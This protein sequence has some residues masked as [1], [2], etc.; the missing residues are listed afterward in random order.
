MLEFY[1]PSPLAFYI[2]SKQ[3]SNKNGVT[4]SNPTHPKDHLINGCYLSSHK[5]LTRENYHLWV[6]AYNVT[7]FSPPMDEYITIQN[8][9]NKEL[10]FNSEEKATASFSETI[11]IPKDYMAQKLTFRAAVSRWYGSDTGWLI[12]IGSDNAWNNIFINDWGLN[13]QQLI[14][15]DVRESIAISGVG[16]S[17]TSCYSRIDCKLTNYGFEQWQI[18][19]YSN[20]MESYENMKSDYENAIS[21]AKIQSG[22]TITANNPELNRKIEREELQKW[23]T[24]A[25]LLDR[26]TDWN[27]MKKSITGEPEIDWNQV[28]REAPIVSFMNTAFEWENMTYKFLP[29]YYNNKADH[30]TIREISEVDPKFMDALRA[31]YARVIVPA[32]NGFEIA[33]MHFIET[34]QVWN[35]GDIPVLNDPLFQSI[36]EDIYSAEV[37]SNG[38]P[39]GAPWETKLPTTLIWLQNDQP[40]GQ[41]P[42]IL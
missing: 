41:L 33:I 4:V 10:K 36:A 2:F 39:E 7:D 12:L 21:A 35:G 6:T 17:A 23:C 3:G 24:E 9:F 14:L 42:I 15:P 1:I 29:Y 26:F 31:G 30:P 8:A 16:R 11:S 13:P 25:M 34:G 18:E 20:I 37:E 40:D 28:K 19:T 32:T 27:A 5:D 38:K 22:N